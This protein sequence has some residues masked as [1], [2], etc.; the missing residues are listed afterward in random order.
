M[1]VDIDG[2][3][4]GNCCGTDTNNDCEVNFLDVAL[5]AEAFLTADPLHDFNNDGMVNFLDYPFMVNSI[6]EMPGPSALANCQ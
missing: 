1:Q 3:G 4:F 6:F 5:F 2:D